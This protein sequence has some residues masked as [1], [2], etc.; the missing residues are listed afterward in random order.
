MLRTEDPGCLAE[1]LLILLARPETA[2]RCNSR[3]ERR[4]LVPA[5]PAQAHVGAETRRRAWAG[6]RRSPTSG[7]RSAAAG[8]D[9]G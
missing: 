7:L 1:G 4:L 8:V 6:R 9:G 5:G 2:T 3:V